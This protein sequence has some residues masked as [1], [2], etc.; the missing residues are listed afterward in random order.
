MSKL[1]SEYMKTP[2]VNVTK[3]TVPFNG[4]EFTALSNSVSII[5]TLL[6]PLDKKYKELY[7]GSIIVA[8]SPYPSYVILSLRLSRLVGGYPIIYFHHLGL[9]L[10]FIWRRGVVR[11]IINFVLTSLTLSACKIMGIPIFLD[12]PNSCSIKGLD[13]FKDED[14]P[15]YYGDSIVN[16]YGSKVFDL[17]YVGRFEKHKGALDIIKVVEILKNN[18]ILM[19]VAIV[20][21]INKRFKRSISKSLNKKGLGDYFTFFGAVDNQTKFKILMSSR[22]YLHLSYEEGWGMSVMDAA[23]IGIPIIAYNLLAYSYLN[24]MF[25]AVKIGDIEGVFKAIMKVLSNYQGAL[26]VS[27]RAKELVKR[28]NYHDIAREQIGSYETIIKKKADRTRV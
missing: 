22:I 6:Y 24:G 8:S 17:C 5:R 25:N 2:S 23:Y 26:S 27:E 3:M 21:N 7:Q 13:I 14:A 9:S 16:S 20:G 4:S 28:Y 12:N 1:I 18:N 15:E 10:R 11:V 19:K